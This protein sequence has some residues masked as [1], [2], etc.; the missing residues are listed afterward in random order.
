MYGSYKEDLPRIKSKLS[1]KSNNEE[2][3]NEIHDLIRITMEFDT[4]TD[5]KNAL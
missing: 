5:F 2:P 3:W 1:E 4:L